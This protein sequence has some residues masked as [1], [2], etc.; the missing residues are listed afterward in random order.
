MAER[1]VEE[2]WCRARDGPAGAKVEAS[3]LPY[4]RAFELKRPDLRFPFAE[5]DSVGRDTAA[6]VE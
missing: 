2:E 5:T 4:A 1:V 6:L 3:G